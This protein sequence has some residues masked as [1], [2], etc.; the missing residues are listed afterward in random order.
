MPLITLD[1]FVEEVPEDRLRSVGI[2]TRLEQIDDEYWLIGYQ[3]QLWLDI[4]NSECVT[5]LVNEEIFITF[6]PRDSYRSEPESIDS[7]IYLNHRS[8]GDPRDTMCRGGMID[9]AH[10]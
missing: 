2:V 7:Y 1:H 9:P 6:S 8:Q 10:R 3:Y 5:N 4:E